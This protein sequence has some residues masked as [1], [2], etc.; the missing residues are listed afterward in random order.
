MLPVAL[1][2]YGLYQAIVAA[3]TLVTLG[4]NAALMAN[5]IGLIVLGVIALIAAFVL[6][7]KYFDPIDN[8]IKSMSNGFLNIWDVLLLLSG[9]IGWVILAAKKVY[10]NWSLVSSAIISVLKAP[11]NF[12][13]AVSKGISS[14]SNGFLDV[15]DTILILMGP[16]GWLILAGKKMWESWGS[17]LQKISN[18]FAELTTGISNTFSMFK[19]IFSF[20]ANIPFIPHFAGGVDNFS[21]GMAMVGENGPEMV[22]LPQN[23]NVVSN[24]NTSKI[25]DAAMSLRKEQMISNSNT[26]TKHSETSSEKIREIKEQAQ[27]DNRKDSNVPVILKIYGR[28][29]GKVIINLLDKEMKLNMVGV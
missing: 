19:N 5:P 20:K 26:S 3:V 9:P 23:S 1:P 8:W 7:I 14:L 10:E 18:I 13:R 27:K 11:M 15:Y 16:I 6:L 2:I 12:F 21:G 24:G 22:S 17:G 29:L 4:F 25:Q 28:E